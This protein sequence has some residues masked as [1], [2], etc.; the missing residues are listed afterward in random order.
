MAKAGGKVEA[1]ET[2]LNNA[3]DVARQQG[4]KMWELR[5]ANDF[6][7]IMQEQGRADEAISVLQPIH[8]AIADGD[9]PEDQAIAKELL[10]LLKG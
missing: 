2:H 3:L 4:A 7:R 1:A 10:V 8:N 5:A 6:A 9:C